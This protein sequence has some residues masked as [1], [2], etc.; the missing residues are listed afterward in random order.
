MQNNTSGSGLSKSFG[1]K[2]AIIIVISA[3]LGSGVFKKAA[4]MAELLHAPWLVVLA[5][6]LAG[7]IVLFGILSIAELSSLFPSSGGP[8][9]WLEK[10]YGKAVS[11]FYGWS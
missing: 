9:L 2:M 6:L 10:I 8:F 7:I 1:L 11:F 4:P 3:I 5:W